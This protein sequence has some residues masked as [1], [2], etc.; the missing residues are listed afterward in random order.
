MRILLVD[1]YDSFVYNL[2]QL[3][4]T[5]GAGV[6]VMRNNRLDPAIVSSYDGVVISPGPGDP[7]DRKRTGVGREVILEYS[8]EKPILG[9]CLGHQEIVH[10]Y[11]GAIRRAAYT[12]HGKTSLVEHTTSPLFEGVPGRFSAARYHSL[13]ADEGVLPDVL[14]V[15]ARALDD[16]EVMAIEHR[17]HPVFGVQFHPE[18]VLTRVGPAIV[19]NFLGVCRR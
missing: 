18:S 10:A 16:H 6:D 1:N 17:R 3:L 11:G 14:L 15:T 8:R 4:G 12:K 13:V 7:T 19:R 9:V 2:Y 5:L